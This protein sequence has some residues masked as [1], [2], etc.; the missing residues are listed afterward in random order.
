[1]CYHS[2]LNPHL[3]SIV[4][5]NRFICQWS[6]YTSRLKMLL[7]SFSVHLHFLID[8]STCTVLPISYCAVVQ[9]AHIVSHSVTI[10]LILQHVWHLTIKYLNYLLCGSWH[11]IYTHPNVSN[12]HKKQSITAPTN[13]KRWCILCEILTCGQICFAGFCVPLIYIY[14]SYYLIIGGDS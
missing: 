11:Y 12:I 14:I 5:T 2:P 8:C 4:L 13:F 6:F 7:R 10:I 3:L 9:D 1:M